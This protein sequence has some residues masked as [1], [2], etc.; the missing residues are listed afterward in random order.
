[1]PARSGFVSPRVLKLLVLSD[2]ASLLPPTEILELRYGELQESHGGG[3]GEK[4]NSK[5]LLPNPLLAWESLPALSF[6]LF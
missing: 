6:A 1:M 2:S 5:L 4:V 3:A